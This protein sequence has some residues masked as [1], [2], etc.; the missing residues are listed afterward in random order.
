MV[1]ELAKEEE[2]W[3]RLKRHILACSSNNFMLFTL[4]ESSVFTLK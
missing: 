4:V 2:R 3:Q 1:D